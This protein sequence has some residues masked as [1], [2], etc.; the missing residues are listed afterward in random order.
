MY[1]ADLDCGGH[2]EPNPHQADLT[3]AEL[4]LALPAF[5]ESKGRYTLRSSKPKKATG[6]AQ[7]VWRMIVFAVPKGHGHHC[8]PVCAD[9]D[10]QASDIPADF[11]AQ[12][13][14]AWLN[15]QL[16][17]SQDEQAK[18]SAL[19]ERLTTYPFHGS[20]DG[21]PPRD[22]TEYHTR[23]WPRVRKQR[24]LKYLDSIADRVVATVPLR[25][26]AGTMAWHRALH[27]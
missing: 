16:A 4:A 14:T 12:V 25:K 26:Q 11:Q 8:L 21:A 17:R 15:E 18:D 1:L 6:P 20:Y 3:P 10:V 24:Y 7:Y 19:F 23:K 22:W 27:G 13:D 9:W 2:V 5:K